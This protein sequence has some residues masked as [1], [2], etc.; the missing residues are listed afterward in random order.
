MWC[1]PDLKI[2]QENKLYKDLCDLNIYVQTRIG[3]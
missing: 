3:E 2:E 1:G